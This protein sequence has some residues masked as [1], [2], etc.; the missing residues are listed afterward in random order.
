MTDHDYADVPNMTVLSPFKE[1]V[2]EYIAG[3][4]VVS[5]EN[6]CV[7][8]AKSPCVPQKNHA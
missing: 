5:R 7:L 3:Y 6:Q 2:V 4:V 1:A 8:N